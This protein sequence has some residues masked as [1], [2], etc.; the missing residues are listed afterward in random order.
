MSTPGSVLFASELGV[1]IRRVLPYPPE[2]VFEV[3]TQADHLR[4]WWGRFAG[5]TPLEVFSDPRPGGRY[6][7]HMQDSA[8]AQYRIFGAYR[9]VEPPRRVSFDWHFQRISPDGAASPVSFEQ[10]WVEIDFMPHPE[11]CEVVISHF[12][13]PDAAQCASVSEGWAGA[14]QL[15]DRYLQSATELP[16]SSEAQLLAMPNPAQRTLSIERVIALPAAEVF[17]WLTHA[18]LLVR[19]FPQQAA[20]DPRV[21]G[22]YCLGWDLQD[23]VAQ[24]QKLGHYLRLESGSCIEYD[25]YP[26]G[27]DGSGKP[28]G[29]LPET[30]LTLVQWQLSPAPAGGCRLRLQHKGWGYGEEINEHFARHASHWAHYLENLAS[31]TAAGIDRRGAF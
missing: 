28:K 1:E 21:G 8:G 26:W 17:D 31:V 14:L 12:T 2:R 20:S 24:H 25:W 10:S 18:A 30:S 27:W 15:A 6:E 16:D 11:G 13:V 29:P 19:W 5:Y 9:K 4:R 3:W 7:L 23:G 22:L